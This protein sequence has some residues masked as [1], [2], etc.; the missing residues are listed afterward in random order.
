[1]TCYKRSQF[2][3]PRGGVGEVV[4]SRSRN[5]NWS[6]EI[7]GCLVGN[8]QEGILCVYNKWLGRYIRVYALFV[9]DNKPK[10]KKTRGSEISTTYSRNVWW[11]RRRRRIVGAGANQSW[12]SELLILPLPFCT[13]GTILPFWYPTPPHD[14]IVVPDTPLWVLLLLL[15]FRKGG[16]WW[17]GRLNVGVG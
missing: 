14:S 4:N 17:V 7:V 11:R 1:M 13:F 9:G 6:M 10:K 8:L 12:P 16:D 2:P 5:K 15:C 3:S